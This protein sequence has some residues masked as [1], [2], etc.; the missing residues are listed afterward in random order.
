MDIAQIQYGIAKTVFEALE[1]R[2]QMIDPGYERSSWYHEVSK[3]SSLIEQILEAVGQRL[4]YPSTEPRNEEERIVFEIVDLFRDF[5]HTAFTMSP[6]Y[7]S[8][9]V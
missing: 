3:H 5:N 2:K 7:A 8:D 1:T 9:P 4:E 6:L